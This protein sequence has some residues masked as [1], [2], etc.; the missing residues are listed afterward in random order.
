MNPPTGDSHDP[1]AAPPCSSPWRLCAAPALRRRRTSTRS[2]AA[3]PPRPAR[4]TAT[5]TPSTA[6]SASTTA[7]PPSDADTVNG[8]ISVGDK[9]TRRCAGNRQ[10]RHPRSASDVTRRRRRRNRQRQHLRRP[11][12]QR[13]GG[14]VDTVNG[15]IGLVDTELG[16]GIETVNGDITV[17]VGSH[18]Q[19]RH[20]RRE[21]ATA[22]ISIGAQAAIP[23]IV[24]GPNAVVDGPLVFER[25]VELYVHQHAPRS[26][27]SPAPPPQ[28]YDTDTRRR[29][30]ERR[31]RRRPGIAAA[32]R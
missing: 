14:D 25:E 28:P 10:R 9:A 5:S 3:S 21:A 18:V 20:P 15:A 31:A 16:G 30:T 17:G 24:I 4:P 13:D 6:A 2:T 1:H 23:R 11:R 12:R 7:R 29:R 8:S 19:R 26:A 32:L 27:R 22:W